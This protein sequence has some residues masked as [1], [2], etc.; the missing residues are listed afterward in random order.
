MVQDIIIHIGLPKTASTFLQYDVFPKMKDINFGTADLVSW[1]D[2]SLKEGCVNLYSSETFIGDATNSKLSFEKLRE[3]SKRYPDLKIIVVLRD[4]E[5]WLPSLYNQYIRNGGVYKYDK[6][7]SM[8]FDER[9]MDDNMIIDELRRISKNVVV[10]NFEEL[11]RDS[12]VFVSNMC[13]DI[14]IPVPVFENNIRGKS[15]GPFAIKFLRFTN[16]FFVLSKPYRVV[17]RW[18]MRKKLNGV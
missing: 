15:L 18:K 4:N 13:K 5:K 11:K 8:V 10:L 16:H 7:R 12:N 14:G 1:D 3:I 6:W 17:R 2:Y 9:F